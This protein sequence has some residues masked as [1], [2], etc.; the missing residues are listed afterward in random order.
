V[1]AIVTVASQPIPGFAVVDDE[2]S[3]VHPIPKNRATMTTTTI[4]PIM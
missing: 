1:A 2:F 3:D 4:T